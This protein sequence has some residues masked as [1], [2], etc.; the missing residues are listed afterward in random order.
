[1][2]MPDLQR[3]PLNLVC[4]LITEISVCKSIENH[5][6]SCKTQCTRVQRKTTDPL[7]VSIEIT[8]YFTLKEVLKNSN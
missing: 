6:N 1:M 4:S 5:F 2:A 8:E 7:L 3:Y